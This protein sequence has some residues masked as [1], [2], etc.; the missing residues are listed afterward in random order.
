MVTP[1]WLRPVPEDPAD[2]LAP[3]VP[4]EG[5]DVLLDKLLAAVDG[6]PVPDAVVAFA[7]F[8]PLAD[9]PPVAAK[10]PVDVKAVAAAIPNV[11][12]ARVQRVALTDEVPLNGATEFAVPKPL[13]IKQRMALTSSMMDGSSPASL[14]FISSI[15][16]RIN[17]LAAS[18]GLASVA[19]VPERLTVCDNFSKK[20]RT[21][22]GCVVAAWYL[23]PSTLAQNVKYERPSGRFDGSALTL[24]AKVE[25]SRRCHVTPT[26]FGV[27]KNPS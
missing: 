10:A 26:R 14:A 27:T 12:V 19:V 22:G 11:P 2:A 5:D 18:D 9:A 20:R 1:D 6:P 25:P 15:A 3:D 23:P 7:G 17:F 21:Q 8:V 16:G 4:S 13:P 24:P